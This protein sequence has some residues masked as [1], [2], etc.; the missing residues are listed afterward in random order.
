MKPN[1]TP[2]KPLYLRV[3]GD[4]INPNAT[5]IVAMD[6]DP[7]KV[8]ELA[9]HSASAEM[10]MGPLIAI[11]RQIHDWYAGINLR[12]NLRPIPELLAKA[13]AL[14]EQAQALTKEPVASACIANGGI[15]ST[16]A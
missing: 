4:F 11:T 10:A 1:L 12:D 6:G 5:G 8:R 3:L 9:V 13:V 7:C 2:Y 16:S 15:P 14:L